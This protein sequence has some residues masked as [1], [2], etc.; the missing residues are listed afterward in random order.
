MLPLM[1]LQRGVLSSHGHRFVF[2]IGGTT[3]GNFLKFYMPNP[4][5]WVNTCA[6]IGPQNGS[7]LLCFIQMLR[8][9]L[10]QLSY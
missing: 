5:F 6:I 1:V 4:K 7:N 9:F 8:R 10:N 3:N 2:N